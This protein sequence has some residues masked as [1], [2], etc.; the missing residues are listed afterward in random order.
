[1]LSIVLALLLVPA[2]PCKNQ[3]ATPG[4]VV[5]AQVGSARLQLI[6]DSGADITMLS[7]EGARKAGVRWDSS[8]PIIPLAGVGGQTVAVLARVPIAVGGDKEDA[9]LVAIST[10]L[11]G[12]ADGLLGM[13]FLERFRWQMGSGELKL[14][15]ID[16]GQTPRP[17]GHGQA[18]WSLR[19]RQAKTR[20]ESYEQLTGFARAADK[21]AESEIGVDPAG[22][23]LKELVRRLKKLEEDDLQ[24]LENAAARSAVPLPWR[25]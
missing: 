11:L 25:R 18:W 2:V 9:V 12:R 19:F 8:S 4:C 24:E 7:V 21:K 23:D 15:P 3:G 20:L 10:T 17:G 16:L 1:M 22:I 13:T 5:E 14:Q 6:V